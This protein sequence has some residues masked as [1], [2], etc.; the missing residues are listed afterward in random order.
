MEPIYTAEATSMGGRNGHVQSS[1]GSLNLEVRSPKVQGGA[2]DSHANPE[3]L[4]AAGY[5]ACLGS[6][7]NYAGLLKKMRINTEITAKVSLYKREDIGFKLS[8]E[9]DV[10]IPGVDQQTAEELVQEGHRIC[11]YS[12]SIRNNVEVV[13]KVSVS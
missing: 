7:I 9:M 6:A 1:T 4:F 13:T 10:K 2:D 11:P 12:Y 3:Q 5:S 8:V